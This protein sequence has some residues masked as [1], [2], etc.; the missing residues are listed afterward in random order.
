[1]NTP[2][3][4]LIGGLT[5]SCLLLGVATGQAHAQVIFSGSAGTGANVYY[6]DLDFRDFSA[7]QYY[8]F[9][10]FS[11]ASTLTVADVLQ[12]LTAVPTFTLITHTDPALGLSLDG[13]AFDGKTK[14]NDFAG[15]NSGQPNGY[16][17]QWISLD[18]A[19]SW[20]YAAS[21]IGTQT[22]NAG[23][24][25]GT[26]WTGDYLTVSDAAPR[27]PLASTAAPEPSTLALAL[28]GLIGAE[29]VRRRRRRTAPSVR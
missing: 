8:A 17:S 2:F 3:R 23:Q 19:A 11:N 29:G 7:P 4:L 27:V 24:W 26:S 15:N 1:M 13:L 12:G 6:F 5:A 25:A 16:W 9:K 28:V 20:Q 14:Y 22:L 18:N 10:Y 21:G